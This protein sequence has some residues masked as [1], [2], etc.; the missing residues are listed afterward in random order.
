MEAAGPLCGPGDPDATILYRA[1]SYR[2]PGLKMPPNGKLPDA[3]IADFRQW[4]EQGG[5]EI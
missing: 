5:A 2:D 1:I 3:V 4:I